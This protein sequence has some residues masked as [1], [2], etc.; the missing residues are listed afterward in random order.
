MIKT[1]VFDLGGV[2]IHLNRNEAIRRFS[3]LGIP[4]VEEM[5]DPYLQSGYF[6]MLEDG[7][8]TKDEFR[9]AL[10]EL[11]QRPLKHTEIA[12]AY[13]GFLEEVCAYKFDY[14]DTLRDKYQVYILSN[15]NP[16]VL[17]FAESQEFLPNGR[18]L[19][20]Y[21]DRKFASCLMG[22]VKPNQEIFQQMIDET[23][24][25]PE[26]TLFIDDGPANVAIAQEMGFT[27][28]CPANG[29]DWRPQIEAILR[30]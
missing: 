12:Y 24:L 19:S 28:Y 15:T 14:I 1:I 29:E 3:S 11:A 21:C 18:K 2:L 17:D 26:E 25:K 7:R 23:G 13:M 22:M 30:Q 5:L 6:L 9:T 8:M 10:S 16:Y 20:S 4:K 27:T